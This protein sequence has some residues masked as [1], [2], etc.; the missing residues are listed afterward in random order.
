MSSPDNSAA[1]SSSVPPELKEKVDWAAGLA[2]PDQ[3]SVRPAVRYLSGDPLDVGSGLRAFAIPSFV[4]PA[5][6]RI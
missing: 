3:A 4:L 1:S 2:A 6:S 5:P